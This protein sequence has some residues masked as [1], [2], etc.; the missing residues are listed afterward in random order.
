M[1]GESAARESIVRMGASLFARRLT[2]G[3]TGN[4]SVRYGDRIFI[5]PSGRSLGDLDPARIATIDSDGRHVGGEMPSKEWILHLAMYTARPGETSIVHTH[6]TSSVAVTCL[7]GLDITD[8]LPPLTAYYSMRV[9]RLPLL[10]YRPPGD[11]SL[12]KL[13]GAAARHSHAL[14]LA[15]HGPVAAGS[16]IETAADVIEEI[17]ETARLYLLLQGH[18][19][20]TIADEEPSGTSQSPEPNR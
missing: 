19:F 14:L 15:H 18:D 1:S 12:A 4:I 9:G 17:E 16:D 5:T 7:R 8:A 11:A 13:V 10:P 3:R 2:H 20:R 6:S